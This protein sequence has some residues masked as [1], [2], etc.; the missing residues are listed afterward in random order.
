M[1]GMMMADAAPTPV[2][3]GQLTLSATV[4]ADFCIAQ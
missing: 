4:N 3:A 1:E 2:A